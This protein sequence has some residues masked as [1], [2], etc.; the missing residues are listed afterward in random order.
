MNFILNKFLLA[1][2]TTPTV[3]NAKTTVPKNKKYCW[4]LVNA[5]IVFVAG[6]KSLHIK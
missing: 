2:P 6:G 4:K 5:T 3:L 1:I